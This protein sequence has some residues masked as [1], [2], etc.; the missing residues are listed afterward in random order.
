M[1]FARA[2][3]AQAQHVTLAAR[4]SLV[5]VDWLTSGRRAMGERWAIVRLS[6]RIAIRRQG[7]LLVHDALALRPDDGDLRERIG[8]FDV[9]CTIAIVGAALRPHVERMLSAFSEAP[10]IRG[11][12]LVAG[13]SPAGHDGCLVR[14]AGQSAEDVGHAVRDYLHFLRA[15]LGD[16]PWTRKW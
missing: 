15:M 13:A 7:R 2:R 1:C 14:I 16:D 3:Y 9:L 6:R 8:R 12:A 10:V 5:L 11:A 4:G